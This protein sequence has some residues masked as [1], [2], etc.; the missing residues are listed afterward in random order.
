MTIYVIDPTNPL[1]QTSAAGDHAIDLNGND[2]VILTDHMSITSTGADASGIYNAG[3]GGRLVLNGFVFGAGPSGSGIDMQSSANISIGSQGLVFGDLNGVIFGVAGDFSSQNSLVNAG[4]ISGA[5]SGAGVLI[6]GGRSVVSNSGS[7]Q[8]GYGVWHEVLDNAGDR[9]ALTNTGSIRGSLG[10]VQ[11]SAG[12]DEI[13]NSGLIDGGGGAGVQLG[14]GNDLYDGRG[15]KVV[16][17]VGLGFGSD[18]AYGGS[19][20]EKFAD[21]S[22]DPDGNDFIDGGEGIDQLSLGGVNLSDPDLT[23]DLRLTSAQNTGNGIDTIINIENVET[24]FGDDLIIGTAGNNTL[25]GGDGAD[26]LD[27]GLGDDFLYGGSGN[28]TVRFSGNTAATVDLN[29]D[30]TTQNT[31]HGFDTLGGIENLEGSS[32]NDVFIGDSSGNRLAGNNG[33]DILNGGLGNDTL[34]GGSGNDTVLFTGGSGATVSLALVTGQATGYGS[35]SFIGIENL[36]GSSGNDRFTGSSTTNVLQGNAGS[37]T[38]DG[39]LGNDALYGGAD[40]GLD[41]FVFDTKLSSTVN[42]DRIM[43]W[44]GSYDTIQLENAIFRALTKAGTLNKSSFVN[45]AAAKD[46]NDFIGYNR[47]TGDVWYDA[48]GSKAGGQVAFANI[49]KNKHIIYSDF[50]VI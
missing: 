45:G 39:G 21:T 44:N 41:V 38:L 16:G 24:G 27:G 26:N 30:F 2:T 37:D 23:I 32:G 13:Y 33:N 40:T 3:L 8:A 11:A 18:T 36:S 28:D 31:G 42:K 9:L 12:H 47:M 4:T 29:L 22:I 20:D 25:S 43:D 46:S 1:S 7:I 5:P 6:R 15:G 14:D 10:G 48:N 35:D 34:D 50:V 17:G 19:G 49:G